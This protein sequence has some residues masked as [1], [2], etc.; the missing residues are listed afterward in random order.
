M[1][2]QRLIR[3]LQGQLETDEFLGG[4]WLPV[5]S[6][7]AEEIKLIADKT[8][9]LKAVATAAGKCKACDLHQT[10]TKIVPGQGNPDARIVFVGEAPGQT[11]D[12]QGLAFVGRAGKLL[13]E[14][15][16]AMGL[17]REDVFILNILK[18]RPP[19]NRDPLPAEVAECRQFLHK[20]LRIIEPEIIVA[21]GA[22]AAHTLLETKTPIGQLRG[23]FHEYY[24]DPNAA[25]IKLA[26]TYHPAYLLR[27]Y[28]PD[29]RR[30]VWQDMQEVLKELGLPVP[31]GKQ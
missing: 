19:S 15:I 21:L 6:G 11:E 7:K 17:T 10:R 26:A 20:Q 28:S 12:E 30:R 1:D 24:P 23:G 4:R 31:K 13:T 3:T 9:Q 2:R 25:P 5:G 22:H 8:K 29:N 27:N 16:K 14:I 18:C